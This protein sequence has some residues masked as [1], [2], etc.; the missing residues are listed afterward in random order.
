MLSVVIPALNA[1]G[2]LR[3]TL[4]SVSEADEVVVVDGGSSDGTPV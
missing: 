3:A 4:A 2:R 1:A